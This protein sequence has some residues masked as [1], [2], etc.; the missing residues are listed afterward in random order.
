LV[1][2]S[3]VYVFIDLFTHRQIDIRKFSVPAEIVIQYYLNFLPAVIQRI[4]PFSLLIAALLVLGDAAQNNEVTAV[5]SS[6]IS[7]RRFVR[8]PI[9]LAL[10]FAGSLYALNE[11]VGTAA[12][13][14]ADRL[15][16]GY[17]SSMDP[18]ERKG[19]TRSNVSG[20]W[21]CNFD[22]FNR[23]ALTGEGVLLFKREPDNIQQ[24]RARRIYWDETQG[25]WILEDGFS[26]VL[27]ADG[28]ELTSSPIRQRPAPI[29]ETPEKL[30]ALENPAET[31]TTKQLRQEIAYAA[32]REVPAARLEVDYYTKFSQP[33]LS[34]VMI[35]LAIP[36]AIRLRR[37]G[38]A[39]GFGMSV[40]IA[41]AYML[42]F[43]IATGLGYAERISPVAAAWSAN[44]IFFVIG[45]FLY[46]RTPT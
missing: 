8:V 32:E 7:L 46:W 13:V 6:G 11:T 25:K 14:E 2:L 39:I 20:G 42:V 34:F 26:F 19:V 29:E 5:T 36:F 40:M 33:A 31:K 1:T 16:R 15:D 23:I 12:A 28:S 9:L 17:F 18:R 43:S 10:A 38:L 44:A 24:I 45:M 3:L 4:A 35:W 27:N 22:K 21:T 37:G 30:F 41:M